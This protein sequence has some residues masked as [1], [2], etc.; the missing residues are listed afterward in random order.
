LSNFLP[1]LQA[2]WALLEGV[3]PKGLFWA[4]RNQ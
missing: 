4:T 3:L 1:S 2:N